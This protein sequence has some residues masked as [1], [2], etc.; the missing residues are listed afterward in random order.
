MPFGSMHVCVDIYNA[1]PDSEIAEAG[2][3]RI[4]RGN[5]LELFGLK[6]Q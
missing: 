1:L 3:A 4:M 2:K 6:S 5:I